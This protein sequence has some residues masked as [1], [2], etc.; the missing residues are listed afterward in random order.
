MKKRTLFIFAGPPGSGKGSLSQL[1]V[2]K[3]GFK[4]VSTGD[5]CRQEIEK[6]SEIGEKIDFFIKSGRLI[7]DGLITQMV[8][9]W[10]KEQPDDGAS[11]L[12]DGYPRTVRQAELLHELCSDGK[13]PFRIMVVE[14]TLDDE[15]IVKRLSSRFVCQNKRCQAIYSANRDANMMPE[16][17]GVCDKCD[18]EVGRRRDDV[19]EV[20]RKR[21]KIYHEHAQS[22]LDFYS[23][24]GY[25]M[26]KIDSNQPI[27]G[28]LH[29]FEQELD[30]LA[31]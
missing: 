27:V 22:I 4:Q 28:I 5:L 20:I 13:L 23:T 25:R 15:T 6:G 16:K 8:Y 3:L 29:Q 31:L 14:L 2:S 1:C 9:D 12:L 19:P 7:P 30:G 24:V 26:F 18:G 17:E 10:F 11:V 21:L